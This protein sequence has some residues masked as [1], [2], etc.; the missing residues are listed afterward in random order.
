[1]CF[2][3]VLNTH[4]KNVISREVLKISKVRLKN[5]SMSKQYQVNGSSFSAC[6]CYAMNT[7]IQLQIRIIKDKNHHWGQGVE[8]C[9]VLGGN[10][11]ASLR[12]KVV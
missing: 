9:M 10:D 1:M 2:L 5:Y 8:G 11:N 6:K 4:Q 12:R 7:Y 3:P